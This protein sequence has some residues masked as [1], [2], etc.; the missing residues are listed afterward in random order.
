MENDKELNNDYREGKKKRKKKS[1]QNQEMSSF[2]L[3]TRN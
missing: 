1:P 2:I 3:E